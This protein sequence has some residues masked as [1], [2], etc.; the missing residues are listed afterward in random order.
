MSAPLEEFRMPSLGADM[1]AGR[2][3]QW[4]KHPGDPLR[5]GDIIAEVDTDKGVIEVEVFTD[6]TLEEIRVP[7]GERVPVGT[8]LATIRREA[9]GAAPE[10]PAAAGPEPTPARAA[11]S[12]VARRFAA[13]RGIDLATVRGTGPG[14]VITVADVE[15]AAGRGPAPAPPAGGEEPAGERMRRAIAAAMARSKR[16]IPHYYL[17]TTVDMGPAVTW[18]AERNRDRAPAER[19]LLGVLQLKAVALALRDFPDF[20]AWWVDGRAVRRPGIHVGM[21]V[22]LRGGGLIAPAVHDTDRRSLD[23]LMRAVADLVGRVRG[24]VLRSS[25]LSE[26]SITVTSLGERGVDGVTGV[27]YPPQVALV[28]FGRVVRRPW[29]VNGSVV[30]RPVVTATLSGDHRVSDGHLGGLFLARIEQ[31]LQEPAAL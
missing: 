10:A 28:G 29:V 2:L 3:V 21:A 4:L 5:R 20:N 16:E 11:A 31:L 6:G 17:T 30:A 26:G 13:E 15:A 22:A 19:I 25:E 1:A 23:E 12:P 8:V 14:G 27:I 18:L 24:G 9:A 7:E